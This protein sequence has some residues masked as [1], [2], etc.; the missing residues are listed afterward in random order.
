MA[1]SFWGWQGDQRPIA[2][3]T[4]PNT[5]DK[6][7]MPE[8]L[9]A[10]VQEQTQFQ[11][12]ART[13]GDIDLL[14]TLLAAGFP[15][16]VEKG[17]EEPGFEGWAGHYVLVT[18]YDDLSEGFTLQDSFIGP[19]QELSYDDLHGYW[20]HFNYTYL[21]VYPLERAAE[22][23]GLLASQ[24]DLDENL[25]STAEKAL[26]ET[27]ATTGRDQFFA[28]FN[29]GSSLVA[30]QDYGGGAAAY[31]EAFR[32]YADLE[33]ETRPWRL[34]WYQDGPYWAY[35]HTGRYEDVINL[36][37]QT[38]GNTI[39]P[40]LEESY[41]WRGLARESVRDLE[42]AIQDLRTALEHHP[43]WEPALSQ[44]ERLGATP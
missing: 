33:P 43:G 18:G 20:R 6:N 14:R 27:Q 23:A 38:L 25:R 9:A 26:E 12:V 21:V 30:L 1:L 36:A 16:L 8:E 44:L 19:D 34:L 2:F 37:N 22:V 41:Y 24:T 42:G 28:W 17:F 7:V 29:R 15:I 13:G 4:K 10:Y 35:F 3:W 31:D 39:E 32:L 40:V 11:V 5:R